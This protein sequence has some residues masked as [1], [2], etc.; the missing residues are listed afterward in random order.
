[1]FIAPER[2]AAAA[3]PT[4]LPLCT[5]CK[6][7]RAHIRLASGHTA[8]PYTGTH[9]KRTTND[10]RKIFYARPLFAYLLLLCEVPTSLFLSKRKHAHAL[11]RSRG[12]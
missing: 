7:T 5:S 10:T 11:A 3:S 1:M 9:H 12:K 4:P 8:N 2:T 6:H